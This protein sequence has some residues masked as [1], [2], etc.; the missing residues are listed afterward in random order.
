MIQKE[1]LFLFHPSLSTINESEVVY[2]QKNPTRSEALIRAQRKYYQKNK[3]KLTQNQLEYNKVYNKVV[4]SCA[5]GD[6][7]TRAAKF[8]H[9]KSARHAT[10]MQN[11]KDGMFAGATK[12]LSR[13]ECECSGHYLYKDRAQHMRTKKHIKYINNIE[14]EKIKEI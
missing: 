3:E 4:I 10:R 6:T 12:S 14:K 7:Y 9:M 11:I 8:H 2:I 1:N 5:C 13:V